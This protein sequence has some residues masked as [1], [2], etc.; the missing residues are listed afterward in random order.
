MSP[1]EGA[2]GLICGSKKSSWAPGALAGGWEN[3]ATWQLRGQAV[4]SV[5]RVP[6]NRKGRNLGSFEDLPPREETLW[7][8]QLQTI[9]IYTLQLPKFQCLMTWVLT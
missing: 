8:K 1:G 6:S 4:S 2:L 9:F 7:P 3:N 5:G